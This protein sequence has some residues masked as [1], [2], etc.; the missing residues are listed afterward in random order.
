MANRKQRAALHIAGYGVLIGIVLGAVM[1]FRDWQLNPGGVFRTESG[2]HWQVVVETAW[3]W[4]WPG[5]LLVLL[6]VTPV[7]IYRNRR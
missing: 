7:V 4:F 5:T 6:L 3:S 1:T 2:T